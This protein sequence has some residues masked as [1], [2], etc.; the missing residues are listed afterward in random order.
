METSRLD[1]SK[2]TNIFIACAPLGF[3]KLGSEIRPR[4]CVVS[5]DI[6]SSVLYGIR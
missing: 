4:E 1:L 6:M 3:E 5:G 2:N